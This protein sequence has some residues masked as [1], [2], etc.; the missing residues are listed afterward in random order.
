MMA[1]CMA[2]TPH[3]V[4]RYK[5]WLPP[6]AMADTETGVKRRGR[7]EKTVNYWTSVYTAGTSMIFNYFG[8]NCD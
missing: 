6:L 1:I 5:H 3:D 8:S 7:D 4:H 2:K